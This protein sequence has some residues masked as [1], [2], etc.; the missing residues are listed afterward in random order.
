LGWLRSP[1]RRRDSSHPSTPAE[2]MK[3]TLKYEETEVQD[4]QMTLRLTLPQKY[5]NG[6]TKDV[7]KLF[8][9]H[10]NKKHTDS[11]LDMVALH[12]KI[13]GGN[14]LDSEERVR[15]TLKSGDECYL[16][17]S[18]APQPPKRVAT[19]SLA[20]ASGGGY[21][22]SSPAP[23]APAAA[24]PSKPAK[25][26]DGRP[27]CK[28]FGCNRYYDEGTEQQCQFHKSPPIFHETA[29][30]WSCC[31][32]KKAYDWEEFMSI[33]GCQNG[34]CSATP[35]GMQGQKK[36][37]GGSDLRGDNAPIRLDADAAP[38]PRHKIATL[39]KGLAAIGVDSQLFE[40]VWGKLLAASSDD[41]K[42]LEMFRTRFAAVLNSAE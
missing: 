6:P 42:V 39:Q 37:L 31:P 17:D 1:Q 21:A 28:R 5:V 16:M 25:E 22:S 24:K 26:A 3:I 8:V 4:R 34:I 7:V 41:E 35:E 36:F 14:H 10:Y 19:G 13:V 15:D 18:S 40:K 33:P 2:S 11:P 38:D 30:W 12:L 9:D 23:P 29:K 20:A 27:R 32:D